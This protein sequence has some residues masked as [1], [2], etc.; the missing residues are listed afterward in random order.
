MGIARTT[1]CEQFCRTDRMVPLWI[2]MFNRGGVDALITKPRPGRRRK[3]KLQRVRD[4]LLPVLE[5]PA[6]A[7]LGAL[8]RRQAPRLPHTLNERVTPSQLA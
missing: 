1:L 4:L 7:G 3:V 6:Q 2:E 8:D 5:N